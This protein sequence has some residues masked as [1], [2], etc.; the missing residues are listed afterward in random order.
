M[1]LNV[2]QIYELIEGLDKVMDKDDLSTKV[3]FSIQRNFKKAAEEV[4]ASDEVR[5][6][7]IERYKESET[8]DGKIKLKEDKLL[9]YDAEIKELF[10]QEVEIDLRKIKLSDLGEGNSPRTLGLLEPIL[11]IEEGE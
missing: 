6:S 10:E 1:I 8:D 11:I 5:N 3:A 4:K 7:I 9:E 2:K